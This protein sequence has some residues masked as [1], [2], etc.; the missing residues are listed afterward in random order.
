MNCSSEDIIQKYIDGECSPKE[1]KALEA[2]MANCE[3]CRVIEEHLSLRSDKIKTKL[4]A[5]VGDVPEM[6]DVSTLITKQKPVKTLKQKLIYG[7]VAA[8][9]LLFLVLMFETQNKSNNDSMILYYSMDYEVDANKPI[10][11]Q[12]MVMYIIDENGNTVE[13]EF[14]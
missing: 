10:T 9:I 11:E 2:H 5:L 3:E 4:N 14:N 13:N 1:R 6:P 12:E 8:C 7:M